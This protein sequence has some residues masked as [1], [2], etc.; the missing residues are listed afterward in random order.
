[1]VTFNPTSLAARLAAD[2]HATW[3]IQFGASWNDTCV[4]LEPTFAEL[5]LRYTAD[6]LRFGIVDV[7]Q[8]P[9]LAQKYKVRGLLALLSCRVLLV[10]L[11]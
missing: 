2:K 7:E 1:M 6:G 10:S 11:A 4:N 3:L 5:S 9:E 8:W